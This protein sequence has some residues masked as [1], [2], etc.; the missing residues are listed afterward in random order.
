[1]AHWYKRGD[2]T[3]GS[4]IAKRAWC[5][6][7]RLLASRCLVFCEDEVVWECQS[8]CLCECGGKQE[9]F[10]QDMGSYGQMLLPLAKDEPFQLDGTVRYFAG[11]EVAYSFW[12]Y[13]MWRYSH[14]ALTWKTDCLPAI[15]AVASIV[16]EATGDRYLAGLWRGDLLNG[17]A[18][19]ALSVPEHDPR[20]HCR[21]YIAP[22][23]SWASLPTGVWFHS[24]RS[25]DISD[26]HLQAS[27]VDAWTALEGHNPYGP[28]SDAARVYSSTRRPTGWSAP[29]APRARP[30]RTPRA[31]AC[32]RRRGRCGRRAPGS[33][34]PSMDQG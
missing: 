27:V 31:C 22:T 26:A 29:P 34:I 17:L 12:G 20:P 30:C 13:A 23:W 7:E 4:P 6:Q 14:R 21:K 2:A 33:S 28:V 25:R 15:S 32:A 19:E 3:Y 1:M 10:M 18:W 5:F 16:A 8:C 11:A 9:D 24:R